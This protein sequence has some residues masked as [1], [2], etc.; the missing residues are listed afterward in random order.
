MLLRL[1]VLPEQ[2]LP[3]EP[4]L[5]LVLVEPLVQQE[6]ESLAQPMLSLQQVPELLAAADVTLT[7]ETLARIDAVSQELLYPMG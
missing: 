5:L 2:A 4:N 7:P 3:L 6:R 1:Q